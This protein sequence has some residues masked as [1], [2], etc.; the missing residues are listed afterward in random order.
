MRTRT[1]A[2]AAVTA[3][4]AGLATSAGAL[5]SR[6]VDGP[7]LFGRGV[8]S[9]PLDELNAMFTPDGT[10]LYFSVNAPNDAGGFILVSRLADGQ[11]SAPAM[12][13]FS[14]QYSDY[15]PFI[16]PDGRQLFFISNRPKGAERYDPRD[17]D[18][19]VADRTATG[20]S[21]PRSVGPVINT[22]R[23]EYFPSVA[24]D[25]TLYFS[26]VRPDGQGSFDIYR[27][28]SVNGAYQ[29]PENLGAAVNGPGADIDNFIAPDQSYLIFAALGRGDGAGGG[30]IYI[31]HMRDAAWT[32]AKNLGEPINSR[33]REYAP[34]VSP[35]GRWLYWTSKRGFMDAPLNRRLTVA[36]LQDSLASVRNGTGNIYRIPM[37]QVLA[38]NP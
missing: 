27:S 3:L 13:T 5:A 9:T 14:G 20:W 29:T 15:D 17:Y 21:G 10:E 2:L 8:V 11:W 16:S 18:I 33:A 30:D 31:S 4:G 36:E 26:A 23:A 38:V 6:P 12:A 25:G 37:D 32:P 22:E 28:R 34:S 19:Y 7:E 35:D 24:S 1:V